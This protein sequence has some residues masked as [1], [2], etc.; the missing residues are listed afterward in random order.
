MQV[1]SIVI[2]SPFALSWLLTSV[3]NASSNYCVQPVYWL[4]VLGPGAGLSILG[5]ALSVNWSRKPGRELTSQLVL[6]WSFVAIAIGVLGYLFPWFPI[7]ISDRALLLL[8]VPLLSAIATVW[9]C[10]KR[11]LFARHPYLLIIMILAIPLVLT[12]AVFAYVVPANFR[13]F[14]SHDISAVICTARRA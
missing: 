11:A 5:L 6:A 8:P 14:A 3:P 10:E 1:T 7:G 4:D 12:S 9:L 13:Y 2:A